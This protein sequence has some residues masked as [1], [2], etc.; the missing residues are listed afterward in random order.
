[1][2]NFHGNFV[3]YVITNMGPEP[4]QQRQYPIDYSHY[5]NS[6]L[7]PVADAMLAFLG[8][9][10]ERITDPQLWLFEDKDFM[11]PHRFE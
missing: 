5:L 10:F 11:E 3:H 9:S 1:M 6:Q 4:V 7:A 2:D 8:T